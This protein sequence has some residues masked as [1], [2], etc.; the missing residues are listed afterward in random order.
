MKL[1][2]FGFGCAAALVLFGANPASAAEKSWS[3]RGWSDLKIDTSCAKSVDIQPGPGTVLIT[4]AASADH[5]EEIDS[6]WVGGKDDT[7]ALITSRHRTCYEGEPTLILR[8]TVPAGAAV[9]RTN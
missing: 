6:L 9:T 5:Q 8:I 4:V 2:P 3:V 1:D 7:T